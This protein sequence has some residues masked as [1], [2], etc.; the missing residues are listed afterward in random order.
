MK[1]HL[2]F[3]VLFT[4]LFAYS[5]EISA[6]LKVGDEIEVNFTSSL[7]YSN[8]DSGIV[9]S[10]EFRSTGSGYIKLYFE[11]F[12]L[13]TGDFLKIYGAVS[14]EEII[15]TGS[16]KVINSN[17]TLD[18]FWSKT[19]WEDHIIVELHSQN[20]NGNHYG[21][22]I[23]KV[24]YGY[25][26]D[27]IS[28][29]F[30]I[31]SQQLETVCSGD[32]REQAACYDGTEIGR[33]SNAICRLLIGGASLCTGWLIGTEGHI[34]TNNHCIGDAASAANTEFLFNFRNSDCSGLN[35]DVS[36]LVASSSTFIQTNN[37]LDFTL[38][39]LPVNPTNTYGY[40][41]LASTPPAVGERIYHPQHPGG[42]RN[43]IAVFTDTN[44]GP[45]GYTV[46][47]NAGDGGARVEYFHD[48]EGG[49]SGSPVLRYSDHLVIGLHNT[50]GCPNG[51]AGRSDEIINALGSIITNID[52]AIDDPNPDSPRISFSTIPSDS[53]EGSDCTF[54]EIIFD[55]RIA[56]PPSENADVT[57]NTS[58]TA[59]EGTDFE[60]LSPNPITFLAGEDEDKQITLRIYND[61]Y[62]EG[63]EDFTLSLS[64]DANDGDA[65]LDQNS[66]FTH[67]IMD[68]DYGPEI[69]SETSLMTEDFESDLSNW[70]VT[71][72]GTSNFQIGNATDA[73]SANWS[74]NGNTTNF[75]FVNDDACNCD[76]SEE[77]LRYA[78]NIDL[79]QL[80]SA[81]LNF[82]I[83][84]LDSNDQYASDLYVQTSIDNGVSWQN[85][86]SE[87]PTFNNWGNMSV[88]LSSVIGQS[89]V[90]VSFLYNDLSNWSYALALDNISLIG[91]GEAQIQTTIN[92][93]ASNTQSLIN[94]LGT[95]YAYDSL[96]GNIMANFTN[97][98][99]NNFGCTGISV[100]REGTNGVSHNGSTGVDLAMEKQFTISSTEENV[101]GNINVT[102]Y[103]TEAEIAGWENAVSAAGGSSTRSDLFMERNLRTGTREISSVTLGTYD[104]GVTLTGNFAEIGGKYTF[105]PNKVLSNSEN[106]LVNFTVYPNPTRDYINIQSKVNFNKVELYSITGKK[107]N[108]ISNTD[109]LRSTQI[110]MTNLD[111]GI[112][113]IKIQNSDTNLTSVIKIIKN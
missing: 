60:I 97:N 112:Y 38:V 1:K 2:L 68:D 84:Y 56:L 24:A 98:A 73:S 74:A 69:G 34:M 62:V 93:G 52:G 28:G 31:S 3:L 10:K 72:N 83:K 90:L 50:G 20:G 51:A 35:S 64:L 26:I 101:N 30:E 21:F 33:K 89:N 103:F 111:I 58:G 67:T 14:G 15:Y 7:D 78:N 18:K 104:N 79:S 108:T 99:N 16:G 70:V 54:Q 46:V 6:P 96:S 106:D 81:F 23:T 76:M 37:A 11:N 39:Q 65:N 49:S 77:R 88:D 107:I 100:T 59:T 55:L 87:I 45:N 47:T 8:N 17:Q 19:I 102:F 41:S 75:I 92:S 63:N 86:G 5:Q 25:P 44:P 40:L 4:G 53:S 91:L 48:T 80:N 13:N 95:M 85:A 94:G 22:D 29:A 32:E 42:R 12:D 113:F 57:I 66:S 82:D 71:G 27:K 109:N 110:D 36:D 61:A 43:E 9:Y 105:A